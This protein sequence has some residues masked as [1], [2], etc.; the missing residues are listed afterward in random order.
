MVSVIDGDN[1]EPNSSGWYSER[2][3]KTPL[4]AA[5]AYAFEDPLDST[6]ARKIK[7]DPQ[8]TIIC[9]IGQQV[10]TSGKQW[11]V[12]LFVVEGGKVVPFP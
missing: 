9:V 10:A 8:G 11:K 6:G 12:Y 4:E 3:G 2:G 5:S 7:E 1:E